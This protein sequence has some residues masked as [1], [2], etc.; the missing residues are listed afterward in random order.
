MSFEQAFSNLLTDALHGDADVRSPHDLD[1]SPAL[2]NTTITKYP[3]AD[4]LYRA[5]TKPP[6]ASSVFPYSRIGHGN[7]TRVEAVLEKLL[8]GHSVVYSSGLS[9]FHAFL[10]LWNPPHIFIGDGYHGIHGVAHIAQRQGLKLLSLDQIS[11]H[12][13]KG[14]IVHLETPVNPTGLAFDIAHYAQLAHEKGAKL[15]V[16]ATFA[17]PPLLHPFKHGADIILH[18]ASK[19]LSGHSD[20]LAGVL[21]TKDAET[22]K[23]LRADRAFLGTILPPFETWLLLRSLKTYPLRLKQQVQNANKLV[24]FLDE[25]KAKLPKL[26]K[27]YA[28]QLQT[29][30]FVKRQL[31]LGGSPT[32]AFEARDEQTAKE[33]P[34]KLKLFYHSTSLGS[35]HSLIEWRAVT[36][37]SVDPKLLRVSVG[38]ER[39]EDLV[40]DLEQALK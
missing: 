9:A 33:V 35:V 38:V 19:Y 14:D 32:F 34:S 22:A 26:G 21:V 28:S 25:N 1:V 23:R 27:I 3:P 39:I 18:S 5:G 16:D 37:A 8:D 2:H 4:Q 24:K 17:P 40:A 29:E 20:V 11:Q 7:A 10:Q 30:D 36:D 6:G 31:P 13:E 12:A 15:V